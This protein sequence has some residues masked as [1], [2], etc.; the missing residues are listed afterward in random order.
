MFLG[1]TQRDSGV[2][3]KRESA[4]LT[5][6]TPD[7]LPGPGLSGE[8]PSEATSPPVSLT[9]LPTSGVVL[10]GPYLCRIHQALSGIKRALRCLIFLDRAQGPHS[11]LVLD[12][13]YYSSH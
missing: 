2:L 6:V 12:Q 4:I 3:D 13:D 8:R 1:H 7:V 9:Q 10:F 11:L 5:T